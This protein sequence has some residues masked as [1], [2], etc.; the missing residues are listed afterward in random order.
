MRYTLS[1]ILKDDL[2]DIANWIA[3]DNPRRAVTFVR[4]MR[5]EIRRISQNPSHYQL[6]PEIGEEARLAVFGR[7]V[8]LFSIDG[9]SVRFERVVFGGRNLPA[10]Y[11]Q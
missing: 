8:I 7:Y 10:L 6:R 9:D 2:E 1:P 3:Q 4:E 11:Q 5:E